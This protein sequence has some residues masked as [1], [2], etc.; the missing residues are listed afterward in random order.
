MTIYFD[1]DGTIADLYGVENWLDKLIAENPEPY[2]VAKPIGNM[3][4]LAR[5]LNLIQKKGYTIGIISWLSKNSTP[6]YDEKVKAAK[7]R[8]LKKHL[9]SV[10]WDIIHIT[11]YGLCK[12]ETGNK[13]GILFDDED[14]NRAA[15]GN[16]YAYEPI[17][18]IKVLKKLVA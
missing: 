11:S 12:W 18:I 10:S 5:Y 13:Q 9:P 4:L 15:W 17:D 1:M 6:E 7:L 16:E 8:W 3:S 2:A 14:K